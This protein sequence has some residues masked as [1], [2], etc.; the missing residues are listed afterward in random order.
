MELVN[1]FLEQQNLTKHTLQVT[2]EGTH[3]YTLV[4]CETQRCGTSLLNVKIMNNAQL[5]LSGS[6]CLALSRSHTESRSLSHQLLHIVWLC[7]RLTP[8]HFVSLSH[9]LALSTSHLHHLALSRSHSISLCLALTPSGFVAGFSMQL[10][11]GLPFA[12]YGHGKALVPSPAE[13]DI[14]MI[15][16]H[17]HLIV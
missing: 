8:S 9:H 4:H 14:V 13:T 15:A 12:Q 1:S 17:Y 7:Q 6:H 11:F 3:A 2:P 10:N 5:V 16:V